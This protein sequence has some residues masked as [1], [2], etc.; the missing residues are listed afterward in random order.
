MNSRVAIRVRF[1]LPPASCYAMHRNQSLKKLSEGLRFIY[2][3]QSWCRSVFSLGVCNLSNS[4]NDTGKDADA[5]A[6]IRLSDKANH[7]SKLC[8]TEIPSEVKWRSFEKH[9][10]CVSS[11]RFCDSAC[12][13]WD[14]SEMDFKWTSSPLKSNC[15]QESLASRRFNSNTNVV[16]KSLRTL[17]ISMIFGILWRATNEF[18]WRERK[19][20]IC[21]RQ[22]MFFLL[23][24]AFTSK[25]VKFGWKL[26]LWYS[27]C[28]NFASCQ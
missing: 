23:G 11:F 25:N 20:T 6:F 16:S 3:L 14:T 8:I 27:N 24:T 28:N 22:A 15:F 9:F 21:W 12:W 13:R 1:F 18:F 2:W 17:W 5:G 26:S 4:P 10:L 7:W 19:M